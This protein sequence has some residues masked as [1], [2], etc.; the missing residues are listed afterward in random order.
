MEKFKECMTD[1]E[2]IWQF[3]YAFGAI[4]G[5]HLPIKCPTGGREAN[6]EYHNFKEFFSVVLMS[7]VDAKGQFIWASCGIPGNTHDSLIFQSSNLYR[8]IVDGKIIPQLKYVEGGVEIKPLIIGDSAF[9]FNPW[10][11]KPFTNSVLTKDQRYFNYRLSRARMIIEG[12]YGQLK[13]RWR[14]LM[15]KCECKTYTVK[16]MALAAIVLHNLCIELEDTGPRSWDLRYDDST[17]S[18]R[19]RDLV[20]ELLLMRSCRI[21]QKKNPSASL[22]REKLKS[23]FWS[24]YESGKV[25]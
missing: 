19:P 9:E 23:K 12:A 15:R 4:D 17:N 25:C 16:M 1:F 11:M 22:I 24:E 2:Q 7:L 20:R 6:K 13:G 10:M 14:V 18:I 5:C 21:V 8:N 3:P